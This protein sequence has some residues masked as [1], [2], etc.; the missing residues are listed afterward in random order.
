M[1]WGGTV[2]CTQTWA[3]EGCQSPAPMQPPLG[4]ADVVVDVELRQ[5]LTRRL[6][7]AIV[8]G[9]ALTIIEGQAAVVTVV[10]AAIADEFA[11]RGSILHL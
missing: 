9:W 2:C 7:A 3:K 1:T 4:S 8:I 6:S 5:R 11:K 10:S